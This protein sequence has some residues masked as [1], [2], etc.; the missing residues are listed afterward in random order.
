MAVRG[1]VKGQFERNL[2][3]V[4]VGSMYNE[5]GSSDGSLLYHPSNTKKQ[6]RKHYDVSMKKRKLEGS[7]RRSR[8]AQLEGIYSI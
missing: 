7:T 4:S 5:S 3:H 6:A 8:Q 2:A 1:N